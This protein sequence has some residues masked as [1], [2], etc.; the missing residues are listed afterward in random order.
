MADLLV[1]TVKHGSLIHL[2]YGLE[3]LGRDVNK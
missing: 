2:T 3:K 1:E